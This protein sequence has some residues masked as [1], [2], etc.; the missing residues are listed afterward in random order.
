MRSS[1]PQAWETVS[2]IRAI[3]LQQDRPM[4][5]TMQTVFVA[6]A[7]NVPAAQKLFDESNVK[8]S[9]RESGTQ[10]RAG[11]SLFNNVAD[12]ERF[13]EVLDQLC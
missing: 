5:L 6:D 3:L 8:V 7:N 13:L 9:F 4:A 11:V 10:I 12:V 2:I 1:W